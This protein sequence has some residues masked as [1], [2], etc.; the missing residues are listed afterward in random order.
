MKNEGPKYKKKT[1]KLIFKKQVITANR[2]SGG[3]CGY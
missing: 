2:L 1:Q 3:G